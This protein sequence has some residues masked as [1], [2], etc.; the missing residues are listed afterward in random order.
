MTNYVISWHDSANHG[1]SKAKQDVEFFLQNE[2]AKI[3]DTPSG[4]I[5]KI[6]MK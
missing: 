6:E 4:K 3:I 2:G 5:N 1:G